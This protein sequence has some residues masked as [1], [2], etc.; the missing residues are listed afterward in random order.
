[1]APG[2]QTVLH[3]F[4]SNAFSSDERDSATGALPSRF[5]HSISP[6]TVFA[7]ESHDSK[8]K[9]KI[10]QDLFYDRR[11]AIGAEAAE[12]WY[13]SSVRIVV[14]AYDD[15][16]DDKSPDSAK[17][18]FDQASRLRDIF[19]TA[20][21][22]Y[23]RHLFAFRIATGTDIADQEER[24]RS[25]T[26]N[27]L[28]ENQLK[29]SELPGP[30]EFGTASMSLRPLIVTDDED[31]TDESVT[32]KQDSVSIT[33]RYHFG[34]R[35]EQAE[36]PK[37]ALDA[38]TLAL[39]CSTQDDAD[40][41]YRGHRWP[42]AQRVSSGMALMRPNSFGQRLEDGL[43]RVHKSLLG[44]IDE[45]IIVTESEGNRPVQV[46]TISAPGSAPGSGEADEPARRRTRVH[47]VAGTISKATRDIVRI[48]RQKAKEE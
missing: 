42:I 6:H 1:M 2:V 4:S 21:E 22:P 31:R 37:R 32:D 27:A 36:Q 45:G 29:P 34:Y 10:H 23:P 9:I 30:T 25:I 12:G 39:S 33:P 16:D 24:L 3:L 19:E 15:D 26:H 8:T 38:T 7:V 46:S 41:L 14:D 13:W 47:D 44:G 11:C 48:A 17:R 18:S 43:H 5:G 40:T 28:V 35:T 20:L